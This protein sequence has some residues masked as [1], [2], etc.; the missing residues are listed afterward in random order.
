LA[1][2]GTEGRAE[3][4]FDQ[5][6]ALYSQLQRWNHL[7]SRLD[8]NPG[9]KG[10][11]RELEDLHARLSA[12]DTWQSSDLA[13]TS[14][15]SPSSAGRDLYTL[16][17]AGCH[18][19]RADGNGRAA[20]HLDPRPRDFRRGQFRLVSTRNAIPSKEDI[21]EVIRQG[22]PGTSM[23]AFPN[24]S[25]HER[26]ALAEEVLRFREQGIRQELSDMDGADPA[27]VEDGLTELIKRRATSDS[28]E[29]IPPFHSPD[30]SSLARGKAAFA[31]LGCHNCHDL[32]RESRQVALFFDREGQPAVARNLAS[33]P[34]KGGDAPRS[35]YL[36]LRLGMPGTAHPACV[37][38][39]VE[40]LVDLVH[41]CR[42]LSQAPTS[43]LTN[44]QRSLRSFLLRTANEVT[45][46]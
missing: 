13:E 27:T 31:Q 1:F 46:D 3:W 28:P 42:S 26:Y 39:P 40:Q 38:V 2:H 35:I 33:D 36:R 37:N 25:P 23:P 18:G 24:L 15:S 7:R 44:Y 17:C 16:H 12:A 21:S 22:M 14:D 34:F 10:V 5:V 29:P 30:V 43:M 11:S 32:N 19:S 4:L 41:Y 9:D 8:Q 6:D 45:D 20:Q